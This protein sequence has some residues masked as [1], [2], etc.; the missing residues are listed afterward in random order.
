VPSFDTSGS[1]SVATWVRLSPTTCDGSRDNNRTILS[2]DADSVAANNHVSAF[3]LQ[4]NCADQ[5][6]KWLVSDKNL[7]VPSLAGL[8]TNPGTA[9]IGRWTLLAAVFD[10]SQNQFRLWMD[11]TLVQ[12]TAPADWITSHG[13]GWK[14]TGPVVLGRY[15]WN[16]GDGGRVDAEIADVRLWNRV[17]VPDD[18]NGTDANPATGVPASTGIASPL[19]VG[20]WRFPDGECFCGDTPDG[21]VFTRKATLVP[22]WTLDP[23]WN[24]DPATTPAWLTADSHD[25][26]GGLRVDGLTGYASTSDDRGTMDPAD[27]IPHPVL[28]TDQ[29]VT[30]TA[31]VKLD[32]QTN[33]DQM[34]VA[35]API[36][37]FFRGWEHK[38]GM[39]VQSPNGSGGW[40]NAEAASNVVA[41]TGT[42]VFI[43]G[44]FDAPTGDVR[45]YINGVL[46]NG[47]G[48]GA[49][50]ANLGE[51]L[52][53]GARAGR[54]QFGGTIDD[55]RV[56][57][58]ALNAREIAYLYATT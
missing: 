55:A 17:I 36:F 38:W 45:L 19:E 28:R 50:G 15:R 24:G 14:A 4:Y 52:N 11:G 57:Q 30:M 32:Q 47:V 26:N 37:L 56:W 29:S 16:D 31:W 35:Q 43:A 12:V 25:G 2:M 5:R 13:A 23:N 58:G 42:W 8:T 46:Q 10:E 39:T 34:V 53:L 9:V 49:K 21:S 40:V 51:S 48:H 7:A 22:N 44:V 3:L 54:W 33:A 41:Q 18:I 1:F 6:F 27:D 20:S